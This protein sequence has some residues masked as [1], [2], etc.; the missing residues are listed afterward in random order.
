MWLWHRRT[1]NQP[2]TAETAAAVLAEATAIVEGRTVDLYR[3]KHRPVPRW[4]WLNLLAHRPADQLQAVAALTDNPDNDPWAPVADTIAARL[5]TVGPERAAGLQAGLLVT[6]EL[7]A[8]QR[9]GWPAKPDH[10]LGAVQ[11]RLNP[12]RPAQPHLSGRS[13]PH[14]RP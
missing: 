8:L 5:I 4:A 14:G 7:E 6:L 12:P 3:A 13:D 1:Y 10:V 11:R 2:F 9:P